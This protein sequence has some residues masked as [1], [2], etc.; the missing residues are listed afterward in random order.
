MLVYRPSKGNFVTEV[1]I[2]NDAEW[3]GESLGGVVV[4]RLKLPTPPRNPVESNLSAISTWFYKDITDYDFINGSSTYRAMYIGANDK[5][6]ENELLGTISASI[7]NDSGNP[8]LDDSVMLELWRE[9]GIYDL[10]SGLAHGSG[11]VLDN[12]QDTTN[13]L[14]DAVWSSSIDINETLISGQYVKIWIKIKSKNDLSLLESGDFTYVYT[15]NGLSIPVSRVRGRLNVSKVYSVSLDNTKQ[16]NSF[17]VHQTLPYDFD[18][19]KIVKIVDHLGVMNVFYFD[20]ENKLKIICV[21]PDIDI[22]E[23]KYV[24]VDLSPITG[25]ISSAITEQ[26]YTEVSQCVTIPPTGEPIPDPIVNDYLNK[27]FIVDIHSTN[28]DK[29]IFYIFFNEFVSDNDVEYQRNYGHKLYI[30]KNG[31]IKVD[32]ENVNSFDFDTIEPGLENT[33]YI[34]VTDQDLVYEIDDWHYLTS[35]VLLDDLFVCAGFDVEDCRVIDNKG[36]LD[37][38]WEKDIIKSDIKV[39]KTLIPKVDNNTLHTIK[40]KASKEAY[41]IFDDISLI[42]RND[43]NYDREV[44]VLDNNKS[45]VN[46]GSQTRRR[47]YHDYSGVSYDV[48]LQIDDFS[49]TWAFSVNRE[50]VTTQTTGT[51]STPATSTPGSST[52]FNKF[53]LDNP[54]AVHLKLQADFNEIIA[55]PDEQSYYVKT[56]DFLNEY[57][58]VFKLHCNGDVS[59]YALGAKYSF[60]DKKWRITTFDKD[61]VE[62]TV[63]IIPDNG[64]ELS[65]DY[66]NVITLNVTRTQVFGC[67][68][69]YMVHFELYVSGKLL[70]SGETFTTN[71]TDTYVVTHNDAHEFAG[72]ISYFE[73]REYLDDSGKEYA[74][75]IFQVHTNLAWA[76]LE[77]SSL[78]ENSP[79]GFEFFGF[80]RN[81]LFHNFSWSNEEN[82]VVF[83]IVLQ[84]NAY[85]IGETYNREVRRS[86]FDFNQIDVNKPSFM[87]TFE[88][89]SVPLQWYAEPYDFDKD[90]M[91]VWVKL[92]NWKGQRL[93]MYYGDV[94]LIQDNINNVGVFNNFYGVWLM[95]Q[96]IQERY[97]RYLTNTIFDVG[98]GMLVEKNANG[99]FMIQLDKQ[100]MFGILNLYKSNQFDV[101]Y[102]DYGVDRHRAES[103]KDFIVSQSEG[104]KPGFME[105]RNVES[106][107]PYKIESNNSDKD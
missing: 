58:S 101:K 38:I 107:H 37:Y 65:V 35:V 55:N 99:I 3:F 93:T 73:V 68:K 72:G 36:K 22:N 70:Y 98:E 18:T 95:D 106:I 7:T 32:L 39:Q 60:F 54:Y 6:D 74:Y 4:P 97:L 77:D 79:N 15:I 49:S 78:N 48:P 14:A 104:F 85:N 57:V 96:F 53:V 8:N 27:R 31:V 69:K 62:S 83:P 88:G 94:R 64:Q 80:K 24:E 59:N 91:V 11:I 67:G 89:V 81:I 46:M 50:S 90:I 76:E 51:T 26:L 1:G 86:T 103:V 30:W 71:T 42:N 43:L 92:E 23:N 29:N 82:S 44:I 12:E 17:V 61:N 28:K 47:V 9:G 19:S 105:I 10:P 5:F 84:G 87:F 16:N 66:E 45:Y 102:D 52:P 75:S 41:L 25:D 13:K 40:N 56:W 33:K 21:Q 34:S 63:T 100:Y 2:S 20:E